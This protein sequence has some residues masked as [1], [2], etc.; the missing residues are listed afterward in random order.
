MFEFQDE[1]N[2]AVQLPTGVVSHSKSDHLGRKVFDELQLGKGLMNRT[3]TYHKGEVTQ[4]HLDN[5][6]VVSNPETT[7]VKQIEFADGR[8]IQYEYDPEERITKVI[9]SVNGTYEYTYD[10]LGQLLTEKKNG[11]TINTMTYD[12]YGNI[13]TKNGISYV[14]DTT[15]KDKLTSYNGKTITYDAQGNPTNYMGT[16]LVWEKGRQLK[17]FGS[18]TYT[19]NNDGIRTSKTVGGVKHSYVLDGTNIVKETWGSNTLIPLYDLDGT[20]C[21]INYNGTAYYFYKNLQGDV[22]AIT[23]DVGTVVAKYVYDAWGKCTVTADTSGAGI[24]TINPFRYRGYYY[25]TDIGMYYLQSRYYNP[26]VGRF[27][28]SDDV[29]VSCAVSSVP[30]AF[31]YCLNNPICRSDQFGYAWR[32]TTNSSVNSFV[33]EIA[34][35]IP[36]I[37]S[38]DI[39]PRSS[40]IK[41]LQLGCNTLSLTVSI[42]AAIQTNKN[43]IFGGMFKKGTLE[44]SA[45]LGINNCACF[46]FSA[47]INWKKA[48]I[49]IGFL[50][51]LSEKASGGY[52]GAYIELS[53]AT[54]LL[55]VVTTAVAVVSIYSPAIAAYIAKLIAGIKSTARAMIP[56]L[57]PAI[58]KIVGALI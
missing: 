11:T 9:D 45:F 49:K 56:V 54:W 42:G 17:Q 31:S 1:Q 35:L 52:V 19:Y 53:I 8:T 28:N 20:V 44:V 3:F 4:A 32:K 50:V 13:K 34:Q 27:I 39:F 24:A 51:A 15:W 23:N 30:N 40:E 58:P 7:L 38:D 33:D 26:V 29:L 22:I 12:G 48:Y 55:A 36:N 5:D 43:A 21:G 2:I 10:V 57:V 6:K 18:N 37:Y 14:Y 16:T 46:S 47:G 41:I 25:D